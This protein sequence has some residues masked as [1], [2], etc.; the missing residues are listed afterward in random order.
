MDRIAKVDFDY[1]GK[2]YVAEICVDA[3]EIG[4]TLFKRAVA[5][6]TGRARALHGAVIVSV[7][8]R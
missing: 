7:E 2:S 8:R 6:K 5:S 4:K 3:V 1:D